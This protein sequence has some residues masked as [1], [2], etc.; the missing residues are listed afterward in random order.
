M[1][2]SLRGSYIAAPGVTVAG[3]R[4]KEGVRV[5]GAGFKGKPKTAQL[6]GFLK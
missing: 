1:G 6:W 5:E 4:E 3:K 2:R